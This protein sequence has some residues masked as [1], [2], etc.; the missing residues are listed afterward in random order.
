MEVFQSGD[1][2]DTIANRGLPSARHPDIHFTRQAWRDRCCRADGRWGVQQ[3]TPPL[4]GFQGTIV[5]HDLESI[6]SPNS[7]LQKCATN[8][9]TNTPSTSAINHRRQHRK[10]LGR[11]PV[12][13]CSEHPNS[14]VGGYQAS[15]SAPANSDL[16]NRLTSAVPMADETNSAWLRLPPSQEPRVDAGSSPSQEPKG[17]MEPVTDTTPMVDQGSQVSG[18]RKPEAHPR[19]QQLN[20]TDSDNT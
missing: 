1:G 8:P 18:K 6:A 17:K 11:I 10:L 13:A 20:W 5:L 7:S 14:P 12:L 16:S 2:E 19:S 4:V 9:T 3:P 15:S